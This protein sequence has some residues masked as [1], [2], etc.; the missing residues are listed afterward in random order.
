MK[1]WLGRLLR[2]SVPAEVHEETITVPSFTIPV[3]EPVEGT[4]AIEVEPETKVATVKVAL[5]K[6]KPPTAKKTAAKKSTKKKAK[7]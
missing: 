2:L 4:I 7:R 1:G 3:A 5:K 6:K